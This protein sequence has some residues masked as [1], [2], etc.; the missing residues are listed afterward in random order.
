MSET[1]QCLEHGT[2]PIHSIHDSFVLLPWE[3]EVT[4]R[5]VLLPRERPLKHEPGRGAVGG[6]RAGE[7]G[8]GGLFPVLSRLLLELGSHTDTSCTSRFQGNSS[9]LDRTRP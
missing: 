9:P 1:V 6:E 7:G 3:T 2:R 4:Y 5:M 8:Q